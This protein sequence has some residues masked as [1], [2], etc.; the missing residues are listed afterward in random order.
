MIRM[1]VLITERLRIRELAP[2]DLPAVHQLLDQDLRDA[3]FG[4]EGAQPLAERTRWLEWTI[5]SYE[6]LA[7]LYQPPYG[8]RAVTLQETGQLVG[9]VGFVPSLAPFEQL[10]AFAP[11]GSTSQRAT[12]ELGLYYAIA[13][14]HQRQG[15][16]A[17]AAWAMVNYAFEQL[18]LKRVVATTTYDNAA[19]QGVM[20]KLGMRIERNPF[21]DPQWLQVVGWL[22]SK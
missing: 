1:P 19:S 11:A 4:S 20:R 22:E 2:D 8:E 18:G 21:P 9:L 13:P 5:L 7:L 10:P 15:Y 12:P 3:D 14:A 16:A 17:E 6:Q